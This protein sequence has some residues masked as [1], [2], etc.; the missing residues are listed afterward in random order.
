MKS[1]ILEVV[2][3]VPTVLVGDVTSKGGLGASWECGGSP[4][5]SAWGRVLPADRKLHMGPKYFLQ[6]A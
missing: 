6:L 1:L 5:R 3:S 4:L 2:H